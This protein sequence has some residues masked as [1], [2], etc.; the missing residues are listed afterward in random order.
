METVATKFQCGQCG[1]IHDEE[2]GAAA[3]CRPAARRLFMCR[4]CETYH[5]EAAAAL[6]CCNAEDAE[7]YLT[8]AEREALGQLRLPME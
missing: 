2:A 4:I 5:E 3:C 6:A 1:R 7:W 8:M